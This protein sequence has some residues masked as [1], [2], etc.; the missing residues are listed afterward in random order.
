VVQHQKCHGQQ[1]LPQHLW[2]PPKHGCSGVFLVEWLLQLLLK[3]GEGWH[4]HQQLT[5]AFVVFLMCLLYNQQRQQ[6]QHRQCH[7]QFADAGCKQQ[8]VPGR[9]IL[10]EGNSGSCGL[11]VTVLWY[12]RLMPAPRVQLLSRLST[13]EPLSLVGCDASIPLS[14]HAE[15]STSHSL[16]VHD[17]FLMA[18]GATAN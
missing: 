3:A 4:G 15:G 9:T 7:Q 13:V 10:E 17:M 6:Q 11:L 2:C 5:A 1:Q 16:A 8:C 14:V 18:A 12:C